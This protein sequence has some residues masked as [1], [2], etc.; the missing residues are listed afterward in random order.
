[1]LVS[2]GDIIEVINDVI[3]ICMLLSVFGMSNTL[4]NAYC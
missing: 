2:I 3:A 4:T 1:M